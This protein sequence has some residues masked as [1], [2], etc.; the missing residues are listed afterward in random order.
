MSL[1][2]ELGTDDIPGR[3]WFAVPALGTVGGG[4]QP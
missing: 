4:K 3:R 2:V 1:R